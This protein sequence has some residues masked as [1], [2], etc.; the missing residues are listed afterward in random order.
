MTK[1]PTRIPGGPKPRTGVYA[2]GQDYDW[3]FLPTQHDSMA[4]LQT[5]GESSGQT[6]YGGQLTGGL[7]LGDGVPLNGSRQLVRQNEDGTVT[8]NTLRGDP[9][10]WVGQES[11]F[12]G[13]HTRPYETA[14]YRHVTRPDGQTGLEL[15]NDFQRYQETDVRD[16]YEDF[17]KWAAVAGGAAYFGPMLAGAE[18]VAGAAALSAEGG[19]AAAA[20]GAGA[21]TYAPA[22]NA[23]LAESAVGTAGYGASSAGVGNGLS[24]ASGGLGM[25]GA[26]TS[27]YDAAIA[28]GQTPAQ[29][30]AAASAAGNAGGSSQTMSAAQRQLL[31]RGLTT[32]AG[33]AL[34]G[35]GSGVAGSSRAGLALAGLAGLGALAS[36]G[37][38]A[39]G[40]TG[41]IFDQVIQRQLASASNNQGRADQEWA[42]YTNTF[43]P[44]AMRMAETAANFDTAGRRAEAGAEAVAGVDRQ[45]EAGRGAQRRDLARAGVQL[46]S[47]RAATLDDA[48]RFAQA[49]ASA[50][51][52][53]TARRDIENTGIQLTNNVANFGGQMANRS[54]GLS[55]LASGQNN[56]A[57]SVAG[58]AAN[59]Q[60]Q[61]D[62][63]RSGQLSGLGQLAGYAGQNGWLNG[64]G[65]WVKGLTG[66]GGGGGNTADPSIGPQFDAGGG[67]SADTYDS[68][69]YFAPA[70]NADTYDSYDFFGSGKASRA[71]AGLGGL[72]TASPRSYYGGQTGSTTRRSDGLGGM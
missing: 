44:A 36:T 35:G 49:T 47:G 6:V 71:K 55:Q 17:A 15:I 5:G 39:S 62:A 22:M 1:N 70:T 23:A 67:G 59:Q 24:I 25:T 72:S 53:R 38:S 20:G 61:R 65:D 29:A 63:I 21:T 30:S 69:D 9:S 60:I 50:G 42:T 32:V 33:Q 43:L 11:T 13:S 52:E 10:T 4:G 58:T 31:Q 57:A 2:L 19:G 37:D 40:D 56:A 68:Y 18:G 48:S 27:A 45:F 51:A 46:G 54:M 8:V 26:Q 34:N 66:G 12:G 7:R 3:S 14:T 16:N 64:L 41:A 28:A